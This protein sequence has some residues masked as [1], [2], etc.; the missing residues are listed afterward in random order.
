MYTRV[1]DIAV[2][3]SGPAGE[4]AALEAAS[5]GSSVIVIEKGYSPGG[6]SIITGTVPSK[7]LR[8]TVQYINSLEQS[9]ISGVEACLN[10]EL[11]I[12][13]LMHRKNKVVL[14]RIECILKL[15]DRFQIDYLQGSARFVSCNEIEVTS[16]EEDRKKRVQAEKVIVAV[17][18]RPYHPPDIAF[19]G[20]CILDSDTILTLDHIP[21]RMAVYGGGVIG[22]E[23]A[24]IFAR[25]GTQVHLID[26]RGRI[27][28]FIDD[29]IS[30]TLVELMIESG[31]EMHLGELYE[32]ISSDG[33]KVDI[34][35]K[36]GK[37]M[38]VPALLYANG[39]Q[40]LAEG[41]HLE[42][43]GIQLNER[44]QL[45]VNDHFQTTVSSIYGAGDIIGFPSLVSVSN[46]EGRRAARH[47]VLGESVQRIGSEI[48][49][50]VYTLPEI[51][52]VGLSEKE[53]RQQGIPC[54]SG[55]CYFKNLARG[56]MIGEKNGLLKL[57]FHQKTLRILA[58][59]ILGKHAAELIHIGQLA[60]HLNGTVDYFI[61]NVFNFP[62][63][64]SA[65]KVAAQ[66]GL[67]R[68]A[69]QNL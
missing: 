37:R 9:E 29:D 36:S 50:A 44:S 48:P 38:A 13:Q 41:L 16:A 28:D 21:S 39:R 46:E 1:Y 17:G 62:T 8:E 68:V 67:D 33:D 57:I 25:L 58:V 47:A 59:H 63:L 60:I 61:N 31:I 3:G 14:N 66:N 4:K 45:D 56:Y 12:S 35:L 69:C 26:P 34:Q 27:L 42:N 22:C 18:T 53:L 5:L 43:C 55:I 49:S 40:G 10:Q 23:Y 15:Y 6:A 65:Y 20:K 7:S 11:T 30:G 64:A 51:A 52:N 32:T 24:S 19:D 2:I 54:Q